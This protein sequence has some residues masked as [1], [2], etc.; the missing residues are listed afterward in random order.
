MQVV[1]LDVLA[2]LNFG[3][4]YCVLRAAGQLSG[5]STSGKRLT[6]ASA[7]G[8]GYAVLCVLV[9]RCALAPLRLICAGLMSAMAFDCRRRA[10]WLRCTLTVLLVVFVFGGAV[11]ALGALCGGD[12]Y[13]NGVLTAPVS[14]TELLA[15]AICA[16]GLSAVV[17]RR[18]ASADAPRTERVTIRAGGRTETVRLL[19]D[20]G[21]LLTDPSTGRPVLILTVQS[22]ALYF[23][24]AV[25]EAQP[26]RIPFHTLGGDGKLGAFVPE[27]IRREDGSR[28]DAVVALSERSLGAEYDGLIAHNRQERR[29]YAEH[30]DSSTAE[31][32]R[33]AHPLRHS[34]QRR[35]NLLCRRDGG[36]AAAAVPGGRTG[37]D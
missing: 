29:S 14:R 21:N 23:P 27:D 8:A 34:T 1:Y 12:F 18:R 36:A 25:R 37:S 13:R 28:Y 19:C 30:M 22:A 33:V 15:A 31:D 35:G 2:V 6:A 32:S 17:F 4:D 3:M 16:Y 7:V 24:E 26:E 5:R 10:V 9:P 11:S 20:S